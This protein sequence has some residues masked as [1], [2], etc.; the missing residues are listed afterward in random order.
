MPLRPIFILSLPRSGS[1]LLQRMMM[2]SEVV[3][4]IAEPWILLPLIY[5]RR[6][7]GQISEYD[8]RVSSSAIREFAS[9]LPDGNRDFDELIHD[10]AI[11]AYSKA[12]KKKSQYFIDKTPR[13]YLIID[14]LERIFPEGVFV[15]LFRHPLS[16]VSSILR[17]WCQNSFL[18]LHLFEQD[19]RDGQRLLTDAFPRM[20]GRPNVFRLNYEGIVQDPEASL[21][22]LYDALGLPLDKRVLSGFLRQDIRGSMGDL[23]GHESV[24]VSVRSCMPAPL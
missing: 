10:F 5:A 12:C 13:Y 6:Y 11:A 9:N 19:I 3:D 14:E 23:Y 22:Q 2:T 20:V 4:S 24:P 16:I 7:H 18:H 1:T 21:F 15:F 17:S 8:H